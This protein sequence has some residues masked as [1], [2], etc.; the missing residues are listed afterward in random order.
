MCENDIQS[1]NQITDQMIG[2]AKYQ[3]LT[4]YSAIDFFIYF[5]LLLFNNI[6]RRKTG[7]EQRAK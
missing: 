4:K 6:L 3:R 5:F 2:A 7:T 1:R